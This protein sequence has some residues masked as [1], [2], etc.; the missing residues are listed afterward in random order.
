MARLSGW[1]LPVAWTFAVGLCVGMVGC[2]GPQPLT[3]L[4]AQPDVPPAWSNDRPASQVPATASREGWWQRFD[5]PLLAQLVDEALLANASVLGA[6]ATLRQARALRDVSAGALQPS[7]V[8]SMSARRATG[9]NTNKGNLFQAGLDASWE[10]DLF[11][12]QR[13]ALDAADAT[14]LA[15]AASL[16]DVQVSI[17]AETGLAYIALRGAQSRLRVGEDNLVSQVETLQLTDWRL[18]AG[19]LST[20]EAEQARTAAAQTGALL[21]GLR[22]AVA[23]QGHA[24]AVLTGQPPAAL[25][26]RLATPRAVPHPPADL[27]LDLPAQ[28]L[29]QRPDV[30]AAEFEVVAA[31]GRVTQADA[32]RYPSFNLAGSLG[33]SALSLGSL[34]STG[35]ATSL[36]A[37]LSVPVWDGGAA[38]AQ[39]RAQAAALDAARA[40]YRGT[41]LDALR[42]VEDALVTLRGDRE[43]LARL[44]VAAGAATAAAQLARQ[45]YASGLIDFQTVLETQR[46]QL[47]TQ[48]G[49][50]G[51]DADVAADHVRLYKALGGAWQP[52]NPSLTP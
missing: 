48:D 29:R 43:R 36:L 27:V 12:G 7:F 2:A 46:S 22:S 31:Q 10:L 8:G 47:A 52:S 23:L 3:D 35:L 26:A 5:D 6:Q 42:E 34:G 25:A 44:Q 14:A 28:T 4:P 32:A 39:V 24:L 16:G 51:A 21:P 45:R 13:A 15:R 17:A 49:R 9:S 11:G 1:P 18:Q 20:L 50:A 40:S 37:G 33:L 41:V 38:R 19:L 30:R